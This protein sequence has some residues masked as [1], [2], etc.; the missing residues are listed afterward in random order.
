[1]SSAQDTSSSKITDSPTSDTPPKMFKHAP[2][3]HSKAAIR[4]VQL[5]PDLSPDGLVQCTVTHHTTDAEY[6]CLSYRWGAATPI[7]AVR[8]NGEVF[9]VRQN[10]LDFL[11]MARP[12]PETQCTYWIDALCIDQSNAA[13]RVHQVGQ[14]GDIFSKAIQVYL[15]L[16]ANPSLAPVLEIFR[17]PEAA[18]P[19]EWG[20]VGANRTALEDY[21]CGNEYWER[22]WI[23]Q[24]IFLAS[25]VTVWT[26]KIP[27]RFEHLHWT[28]DFF[29]L[30]WKDKPIAQFKLHTRGTPEPKQLALEFAQAKAL[31]KGTRLTYLL[32][33][34]PEK[35]CEVPRDRIFSLLSISAEGSRINVDYNV[36]D[37]VVWR[38][39]LSYC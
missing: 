36:P 39:V 34:F 21:I 13:E 37:L 26:D 12:N 3:D 25:T 33:Q 27:L 18:T 6:T 9:H 19:Q 8:M 4:L 17:D 24:E 5:L 30:A 29:Y 16:G 35:L 15:W 1:M 7:S 22:A 38:N 31:Y 23:I 2:L 32:L 28:I 10:L 14:M 20:I 11:N